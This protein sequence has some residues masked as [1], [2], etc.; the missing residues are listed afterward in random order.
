MKIIYTIAEDV[1]R[2]LTSGKSEKFI[3][4]IEK[5]LQP[6]IEINTTQARQNYYRAIFRRIISNRNI[7]EK[8]DVIQ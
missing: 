4:F 5:E 6:Y 1:K 7:T 8:T 2:Y 3:D